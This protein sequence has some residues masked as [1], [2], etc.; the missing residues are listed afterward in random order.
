MWKKLL[1]TVFKSWIFMLK[2]LIVKK[3]CIRKYFFTAVVD[4]ISCN[5]IMPAKITR[6]NQIVMRVEDMS[7]A[8]KD[9]LNVKHSSNGMDCGV[10]AVGVC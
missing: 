7:R 2:C 6:L 3:V 10:L 1:V 4:I 5:A 9:V 8:K